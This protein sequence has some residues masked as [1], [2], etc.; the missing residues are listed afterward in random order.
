MMLVMVS[1]VRTVQTHTAVQTCLVQQLRPVH[2]VQRWTVPTVWTTTTMVTSIAL[3]RTT[4]SACGENCSNV[5]SSGKAVDDDGDGDAN[6]MTP[7][8]LLP[9][10]VARRC[11]NGIDDDG[12]NDVDC[13]DA[14]CNGNPTCRA[15]CND[16]LDDD[17]DFDVDRDDSD[18]ANDPLCASVKFVMMVSTTVMEMLTV[19][20][21]NVLKLGV[22]V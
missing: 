4:G 21:R 10:W 9:V 1:M 14:D 16:D 2:R 18:C 17:G 20:T 11:T 6:L 19:M 15:N 7:I 3:I 12:D 5:D 8:V 13:F 22:S